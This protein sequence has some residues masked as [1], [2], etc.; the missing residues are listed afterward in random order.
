MLIKIPLGWHLPEREATPP[1]TYFDRRALLKG[2]TAW[3]L[4]V[5]GVRATL[6]EAPASQQQPEEGR[7]EG[8]YPAPRNPAY[9]LD[10]PL[11]DAAVAARFNVFDEFSVDH[12]EVWRLAE[13][14]A[15]D[16]WTIQVG[17]LVEKPLKMDIEELIRAMPLEERLYRHRCVETWAMAVPWTGF[18][19][20]RFLEHVKPLAKARY[21]RMISFS[22][23][24]S[25][26]GWY[27]TRRV[28]P[29][30]EALSL[31]EARNELTLLATGIYGAPLPPQHG[32]PLRLVTPWKWGLK[33][34]KSIVAF[35]FTQERPDTFWNV[36][37]PAY[38]SFASNVDPDGFPGPWSQREETML[39]TS[40]RRPTVVFNGYGEQVAHLYGGSR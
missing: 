3:A 34:I 21:V 39:G 4:A 33:S 17:G 38:Y 18:P 24:T 9:A 22:D 10:R 13:G 27:A 26:P 32:A 37:S 40:E 35:Q 29:Y 5:G 1:S 7:V 16:P 12:E 15:T 23:P 36:L 2:A 20:A 6:A 28:F 11:T 25:A 31:D 19:F 14:F 30:Y 8:P